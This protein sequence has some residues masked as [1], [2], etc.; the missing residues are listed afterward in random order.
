MLY[1]CKKLVKI[2]QSFYTYNI[3]LSAGQTSHSEKNLFKIRSA[4][5]SAKHVYEFFVDKSIQKIADYTYQRYINTLTESYLNCWGLKKDL[6]CRDYGKEILHELHLHKPILMQHAELSKNKQ[7]RLF[8]V[9]P[10][11]FCWMKRMFRWLKQLKYRVYVWLTG[12]N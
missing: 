3:H 10:L 6:A 4:V 5:I 12:K 2:D 11:L 9:S 8:Y 1:G 7:L